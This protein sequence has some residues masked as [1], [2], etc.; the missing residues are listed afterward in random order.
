MDMSAG[1]VSDPNIRPA[2]AAIARPTPGKDG[3]MAMAQLDGLCGAING[4][5]V[6]RRLSLVRYWK[7]YCSNLDRVRMTARIVL[8]LDNGNGKVSLVADPGGSHAKKMNNQP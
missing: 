1:F 8:G 4:R 5:G 6:G 2:N 3:I 7:G